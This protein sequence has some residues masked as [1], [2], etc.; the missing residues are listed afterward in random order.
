M[1]MKNAVSL[2]ATIFAL[3]MSALAMPTQNEMAEVQPLV[4][5]L[6]S[7][8]VNDFRA[9]KISAAEIGDKALALA[10]EAESL[11]AKFVLLKGAVFYY[12][13]DKEYDKV[14]D[15]IKLIMELV[16]DI[17]P[18]ALYDITSK[19]TSTAA[20]KAAP[21]LVAINN[22]VRKRVAAADRLKGVEKELKNKGSDVKLKRAHAELLAAMGDWSAALSKFAD[23]DG[24]IGKVA[25]SDV[26][27]TGSNA[28]I[29]DFWWSYKPIAIEAKD[30]IRGYAANQYIKA[31]DNGELDGLKKALAEKRIAE[32]AS[33]ME[34]A[35]FTNNDETHKT[36][37]GKQPKF[38]TL[39]SK[40]KQGLVGHWSFNGNAN[41]ISG[42]RNN[43]IVHGVMP[44]EDRYGNAD[45]AY[46]FDG[47][48]HVQVPNAPTLQD[49]NEALTMTAWIKPQKFYGAWMVIMQK[50]DQNDC[51]FH[52]AVDANNNVD[53]FGAN[54]GVARYNLELSKWQHVALTYEFNKSVNYY[55]DGFLIGSWPCKHR[56]TPN[57]CSLLIGCDPYGGMEYFIGDMDDVRLFNRA[58]SDREIQALYKAEAPIQ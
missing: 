52:F 53:L 54:C 49:I 30:A 40:L 21:R 15:V 18:R 33:I 57:I 43:G 28:E 12:T 1:K 32:V 17:P 39:S 14:A 42:N 22:M 58:L 48:S 41:D 51:Q 35:S 50:G 4:N 9:R 11:A 16:P 26:D 55:K 38:I 47:A 19:A 10:D 20:S 45:G 13:R 25:S 29:A 6:M 46:R 24:N 56:I 31:I 3:V 34:V 2:L 23:L 37:A 27:A 5:E 7:P 8:L 44:A 36:K